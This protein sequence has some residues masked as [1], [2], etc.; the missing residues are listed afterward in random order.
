[1]TL[2]AAEEL[3]V[4]RAVIGGVCWVKVGNG[5]EEAED[6]EDLSLTRAEISSGST[7]QAGGDESDGSAQVLWRQPGP[8][9]KWAIVRL[10]SAGAG[11]SAAKQFKVTTGGLTSVSAKEWDGTTLGDGIFDITTVMGH[12]VD[13]IIYAEEIDNVILDPDVPTEK[14]WLELVKLDPSDVRYMVVQIGD[15][16][17]RWVLDFVRAHA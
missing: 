13:D 2:A 1:V 14:M 10:G 16:V 3:A 5:G 17:G 15:T 8:G 12:A 4:G 7:C 6:E 9:E 11:G